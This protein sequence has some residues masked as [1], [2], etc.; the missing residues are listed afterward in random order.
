MDA[1]QL[2]ALS[3]AHVYKEHGM[4]RVLCGVEESTGKQHDEPNYAAD[5]RRL[6]EGV[7]A[8][9]PDDMNGG[10]KRIRLVGY[11]VVT[12]ADYLACQT[13]LPKV[14]SPS[15]HLFCRFGCDYDKRSPDAGR[16]FSFL[17]RR[18][19]QPGASKASCRSAFTESDWPAMRA[20]IERLRALPAKER[21]KEMKKYGIVRLWFALDPDLIP[22]VDPTRNCPV[23]LLHLFP[24]GLLRS[25]LA[26]L[27]FIFI[28]MGLKLDTLNASSRAYSGFPADV[29]IPPFTEK[30]K[31]GNPSNSNPNP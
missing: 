10:T 11:H 1:I 28:K 22:H 17:R 2:I 26:W 14:G 16:P 27:L 29:R 23:D 4:S 25:E 5:C 9:I 18:S 8:T 15:A 12:S 20:L 21:E 3:K 19:P 24:D 30:L 6:A 31:K 13:M 7:W